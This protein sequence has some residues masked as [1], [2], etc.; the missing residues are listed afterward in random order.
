MIEDMRHPPEPVA[1]WPHCEHF[2]LGPPDR[3]GVQICNDCHAVV[4]L[5]IAGLPVEE[6]YDQATTV[7]AKEG[8]DV[9]FDWPGQG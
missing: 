8:D 4:V 7:V 5:R 3:H 6:F 1:G 2:D 9:P